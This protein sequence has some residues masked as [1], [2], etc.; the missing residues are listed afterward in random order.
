LPREK[1][2]RRYIE[3]FE[4]K[5]NLLI[6]VLRAIVYRLMKDEK[7]AEGCETYRGIGRLLSMPTNR[8]I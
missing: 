2:D 4:N 8:G 1:I 6:D 3:I 7:A 5:F